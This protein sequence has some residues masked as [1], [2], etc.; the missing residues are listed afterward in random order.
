MFEKSG[1]VRL[2]SSLGV[3]LG[4]LESTSSFVLFWYK[5]PFAS[6]SKPFFIGCQVLNWVSV[7]LLGVRFFIGCQVGVPGVHITLCFVVVQDIPFASTS[8]PFFV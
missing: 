7:S 2:D 5:I 6:V 1:L 4:F 3:R 8:K